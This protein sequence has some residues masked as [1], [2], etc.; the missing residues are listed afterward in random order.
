MVATG[1]ACL[2]CGASLSLME[3]LSLEDAVEVPGMGSLCPN[4]YRELSAEEYAR[5]F[6]S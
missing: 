1:D 2:R 3:R 5:Y 6:K 4:C